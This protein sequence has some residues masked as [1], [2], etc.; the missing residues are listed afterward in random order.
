MQGQWVVAAA[1]FAFHY[2]NLKWQEERKA[3]IERVNS[4]VRGAARQGRSR[5]SSAR[6]GEALR[7]APSALRSQLP[8]PPNH[9]HNA[10]PAAFQLRYFYG[11]LLAAVSATGSAYDALVAQHSPDGTRRGFQAAVGARGGRG[12]PRGGGWG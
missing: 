11:P 6:P 10:A 2:L 8:T 3:R 9:H 12:G 4:Q 5:G 7:R 1:G